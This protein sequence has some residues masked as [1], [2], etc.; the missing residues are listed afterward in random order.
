MDQLTFFF[1][2]NFGTRL[3]KAFRRMNPPMEIRW[4]QD[5]GFR[6]SSP[7]DEWL[8]QVKPDWIILSQDR[9]WHRVETER[10]AIKQHNLRCFYI[11]GASETRW[12]SLCIF[13]RIHEKLMEL[14]RD[15]P[16]P[17]IFD[18]SRNGKFLPVN[19]D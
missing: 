14:S 18:A 15:A 9:K 13:A 1:D 3:P 17:F 5:E 6:Q 19:L 12:Y 4:H 2:R 8:G 11:P 10:A 16:A 7:D